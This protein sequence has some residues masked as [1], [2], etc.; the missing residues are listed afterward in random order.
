MNNTDNRE[1]GQPPLCRYA[2]GVEYDGSRYHGWQ[3]Q[4]G[5]VATVQ[6]SVEAALGI[7]A[8][9]PVSVICAGRTDTGVHASYQVIHID[10]R[11]VRPERGWVL[12]TNTKLPDDI[13]IRWAKRVPDD[14]HA[15]FS[16]L[17]R[18]YR[19]VIYNGPVKPALLSR[20]LT[21]THKALDEHR[22]QAAGDY[23]VGT[24]DFSSY[25]AVACQAHSPVREVRHLRVTRIGR[26][27]VIDV[28]ANAFL[29]H[30]IRNIAGVL[31]KVG[32]GEAEPI[33]AKQVLEAQD[34]RMGGVTAPPFGLYFVDARYPERFDLPPS[35]LGP[36]FLPQFD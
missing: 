22:M 4:P 9:E 21:W 19:Y 3:N 34:R 17:E 24:H 11:A 14:F 6:S 25:R 20:Q 2:L 27:I 1:A 30:M 32:C 10:T 33:W 8:N 26:M 18:R 36:A 12:G 28:M 16:A 13:C 31:M 7:I 5:D 29:H 23:L 35:E 15:R